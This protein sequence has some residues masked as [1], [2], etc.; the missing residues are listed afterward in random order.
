MNIKK[1][2]IYNYICWS[3]SGTTHH[4][5][6]QYDFYSIWRHC[7]TF[8]TPYVSPF[9]WFLF[10]NHQTCLFISPT[11]FSNILLQIYLNIIIFIFNKNIVKKKKTI[12]Y[13]GLL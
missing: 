6:N 11:T 4:C 5:S 3:I 2:C 10:S 9:H 8:D 13:V 7:P 12:M 1:I